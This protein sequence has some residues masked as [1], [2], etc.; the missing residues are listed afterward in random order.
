MEHQPVGGDQQH[1]EEDEEVEDVAGQERAVDAHE[2]EL[3]QRVEMPPRASQPVAM[4]W[5]STITA[6]IDVS[7]TMSADSRSST[8]T[9]PKG[10]GQSPRR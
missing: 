5:I 1:L 3:E 4:A 10:A 6:R 7:S 8:R 2:L 9:M